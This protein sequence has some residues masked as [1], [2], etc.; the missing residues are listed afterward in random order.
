MSSVP[1]HAPRHVASQSFIDLPEPEWGK[2]LSITALV[3]PM[4]ML[5]FA[6]AFDLPVMVVLCSN[7]GECVLMLAAFLTLPPDLE[8]GFASPFTLRFFTFG[9]VWIQGIVTAIK[10]RRADLREHHRHARGAEQRGLPAHVRPGEEH[11][12]RERVPVGVVA[13]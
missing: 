13:A 10:L 9:T 3:I 1:R 7:L 5:P 11:G 4:S 8:A 6:H 12:V 2:L